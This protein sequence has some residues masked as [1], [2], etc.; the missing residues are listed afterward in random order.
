MQALTVEQIEA[1][2]VFELP[3][4]NTLWFSLV[5]INIHTGNINVLSFN[6]LNTCLNTAASLVSA[7]DKVLQLCHAG[8]IN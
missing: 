8:K 4:R 2:A 3:E 7:G 1:Q 5:Y 6:N